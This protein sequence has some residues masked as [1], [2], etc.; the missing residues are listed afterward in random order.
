[1]HKFIIYGIN[2]FILLANLNDHNKKDDS[3]HILSECNV[4]SKKNT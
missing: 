3:M 2:T 1:M 4:G